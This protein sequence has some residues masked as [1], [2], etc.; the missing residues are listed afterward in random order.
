MDFTKLAEL[1]GGGLYRSIVE[2][3]PKLKRGQV[4][5]HTCGYTESVDSAHCLSKGW[6]KHCGQTMSVDSPAER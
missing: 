6:P 2:N 4:W 1:A 5:C 3:S